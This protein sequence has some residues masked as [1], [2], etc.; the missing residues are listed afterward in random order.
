MKKVII[1]YSEYPTVFKEGYN[2]GRD[3][4]GYGKKI[5]TDYMVMYKGR[6]RRIYVCIFSNAGTSYIIVNKQHKVIY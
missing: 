4:F 3:Q 2:K 1:D 6:L 5:L